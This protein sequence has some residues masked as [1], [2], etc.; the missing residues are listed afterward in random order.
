MYRN[1]RIMS[2]TSKK[3]RVPLT[4]FQMHVAGASQPEYIQ[5]DQRKILEQLPMLPNEIFS[6]RVFDEFHYPDVVVHVS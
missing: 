5:Y 3:T 4:G 1:I 6:H 2:S